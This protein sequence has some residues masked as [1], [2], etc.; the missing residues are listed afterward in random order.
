MKFYQDANFANFLLQNKKI[1]QQQLQHCFNILQKT[2]VNEKNISF[3]SIL[4]SQRLISFEELN[5]MW[6]QFNQIST[7]ASVNT[8]GFKPGS[9]FG[10]YQIQEELG[11]G[12]MGAVYK[13][14]DHKL[15]RS[16]ALK[17]ILRENNISEKQ[18][19]RF[20]LEARSM[21]KLRHPNIIEVYEVG[22]VPQNYFTMEYIDGYSL[23]SVLKNSIWKF[24]YQ[25]IAEIFQQCS[26]ALEQV[27]K[28]G[29]VHRDIKPAN[30]MLTREK[31][32][33]LM[34]FG[35]VKIMDNDFSQSDGILGT[36]AYMPPEQALGQPV[37]HSVDIYALGATLYQ[38][39]CQRPPF[40]GSSFVNI[41]CQII[42]NDPVAPRSLNPN[43]PVDLESICLKSL[44]KLISQ[45][46]K[47]AKS[48]S[49]DL[50]NFI[51]NRPIIA[52]AATKRSLVK[53]WIMRNQIVSAM[54]FS[55][56]ITVVFGITMIVISWQKAEKD[57]IIAQIKEREIKEALNFARKTQKQIELAQVKEQQILREVKL[58][59]KEKTKALYETHI[60]LAYEFQRE[61]YY[62]QARR[63]IQNFRLKVPRYKN[64]GWE[65]KWLVQK[66][67]QEV[68]NIDI[69]SITEFVLS[70]NNKILAVARWGEVILYKID[71]KSFQCNK[72]WTKHF[73]HDNVSSF[74]FSPRNEFVAILTKKTKNNPLS[75]L[76]VLEVK[77]GK[78]IK[79]L[80]SDSDGISCAFHPSGRIVLC[81]YRG[82]EEYLPSKKNTKDIRNIILWDIYSGKKIKEIITSVENFNAAVLDVEFSPKGKIFASVGEDT[83]VKIWE[84]RTGKLI[85]KLSSHTTSVNQ[86]KFSH[87]GKL[88]ATSSNKN[89]IIWRVADGKK[90]KI[91]NDLGDA[92]NVAF[93]KNDK[94]LVSGGRDGTL[95]V[96]QV[97]TGKKLKTFFGHI[98]EILNCF[99][100]DND[101]LI[102]AT[103]NTKEPIK[104]W[105]LKKLEKNPITLP[106]QSN[107]IIHCKFSPSNKIISTVTKLA[108]T[109]MFWNSNNG[110]RFLA[111][112]DSRLFSLSHGSILPDDDKI[113][114]LTTALKRAGIY[115]LKSSKQLLRLSLDFNSTSGNLSADGKLA[116]A[117]GWE[118][119]IA[120]W[121]TAFN[122]NEYNLNRKTFI[123]THWEKRSLRFCAFSPNNK[124]F[125]VVGKN[126]GPIGF[127]GID[128]AGKVTVKPR[129]LQGN[130]QCFSFNKDPNNIKIVAGEGNSIDLWNL[131]SRKKLFTFYGHTK[132]VNS[133]IFIPNKNRIISA[134]DD[135]T[136]KVWKIPKKG[137]KTKIVNTSILTFREHFAAVTTLAISSDGKKLISGDRQGYIKIW[138]GEGILK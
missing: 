115:S 79:V 60:K 98:G 86:C 40:Q 69:Q 77:T 104:I 74:A 18:I 41:A 71:P 88:L 111:S 67:F 63:T 81:S 127:W 51:E 134:S 20:M 118:G 110:N 10:C 68:Y 112:F 87:S 124:F 32:P 106:R 33:V 78:I 94:L 105:N 59:N 1:S 95:K 29:I 2:G 38:V 65:W 45:R 128:D 47:D 102:S 76:I 22:S 57:K 120:L 107:E 5:G 82:K 25:Q 19:Q 21:A 44:E 137:D 34:D 114:L 39:M 138:S 100:T 89:I 58:A 53:K 123:K 31:K 117:I 75:K 50:K 42:E 136:I 54:A 14:Y 52:K 96:W 17:V 135:H 35:L 85:R 103:N 101:Y 108:T 55:L 122:K 133:C 4:I 132:K 28:A 125:A 99:I 62:N 66:C 84:T 30:I 11:R 90:L 61:N 93:T 23:S 126:R 113:F 56:F 48:L 26:Q 72:L 49:K 9:K 97:A 130:Y 27:H 6:V 7:D 36:P 64:Y 43:I 91:F 70:N 15:Q 83:F 37:N 12:G 73:K 121:K 24:S 119:E 8:K 129:L 80:S 16:V 116:M 46:Y 13:V 131:V 3:A 109:P 92:L